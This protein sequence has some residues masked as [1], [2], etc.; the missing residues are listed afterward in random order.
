MVP[1]EKVMQARSVPLLTFRMSKASPIRQIQ[2]RCRLVN[3]GSAMEAVLQMCLTTFS[4]KFSFIDA[5]GHFFKVV[6]VT[7]HTMKVTFSIIFHCS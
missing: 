6:I 4:T 2:T 5:R 7:V 3:D 1:E